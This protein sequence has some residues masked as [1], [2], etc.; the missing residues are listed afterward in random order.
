MFANSN[1]TG[2]LS[3]WNFKSALNISFMFY[4]IANQMP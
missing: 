4:N 2:D 3:N 1:F